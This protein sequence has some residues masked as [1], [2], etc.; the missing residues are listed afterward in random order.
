MYV[1]LFL[2]LPDDTSDINVFIW[3]GNLTNL[4]FNA[5]QQRYYDQIQQSCCCEIV[6][7]PS[8]VPVHSE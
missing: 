3:I 5:K 2:L 1:L 8:I 7:G 6:H 4:R